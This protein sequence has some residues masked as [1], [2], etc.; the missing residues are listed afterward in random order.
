MLLKRAY[1]FAGVPGA[2]ANALAAPQAN[3]MASVVRGVFSGNLPWNYIAIGS[4][5][6]VFIILLDEIQRV[7]KSLFRFPVLAVA[8]GVYL[9][10]E[11][12]VPIFLGG[13]IKYAVEKKRSKVAAS[14][15]P[16]ISGNGGLLFAS[17]LIT[18][19]ALMGVILAIPLITLKAAGIVFPLFAMPMGWLLG[20]TLLA[21]ISFWIFIVATNQE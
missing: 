14:N 1:G 3:L 11:L 18:G 9:P 8:I 19:E 5:A 17:G 16:G 6:A 21:A 7:R 2:G 15:S 20:T 10:F 12:A 4:V 13:V